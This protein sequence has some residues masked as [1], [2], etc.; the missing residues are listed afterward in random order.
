[1]VI[2][3]SEPPKYPEISNF[4]AKD[5][6]QKDFNIDRGFNFFPLIFL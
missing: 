3:F 6:L 1:M 4:Q 5:L 2:F